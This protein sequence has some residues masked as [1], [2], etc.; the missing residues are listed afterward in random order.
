M[1]LA[2][3]RWLIAIVWYGMLWYGAFLY[4]MLQYGMVC[5]FYSQVGDGRGVREGT[6]R[7]DG[8]VVSVERENPQVFEASKSIFLDALE[9]IVGDDEGGKAR[10]VGENI[11]LQH[12]HLVVAQ[13]ETGQR[14]EVLQALRL[15]RGDFIH[16][17]VE[18]GGFGRDALWNSGQLGVAAPEKEEEE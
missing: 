6:F 16:I 7:N 2:L 1:V 10:Q 3:H 8:N 14:F 9:L 18:L 13:I 4:G 15:D 12:G 17:K 11:G 5:L